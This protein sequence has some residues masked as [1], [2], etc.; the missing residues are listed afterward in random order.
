MLKLFNTLSKTTEEI[1]T[2]DEGTIRMYTCGPT[3]YRYAHIGNLR[4]YMMADWIRRTLEL[5]GLNVVHVKN[6]T[7]VGHMR[8]ELVE[9]GGDKMILAALAEGKTIE[10]IAQ[11]YADSFHEDE[12]RVNILPAHV[13]PWAT[14]HIPEMISIVEKLVANG[15]AYEVNGNIYFDVE[16]FSDYGKLSRNFGGDLLEGVRVEADPLKKDPRDFTLWKSAEAGRDVKW[17]SPWG[18]G[19][20]GWHIECSAMAHKYLGETFDIHTG[21]VDNV[22]PHHEDEIAQ[23]E[24]AFGSQHVTY[25]IHGQHLLADGAKMSKS[26]GNV[27]L[28]QDLIDRG[29][30]P[31]AFRYLCGTVRYRHRMNFTFTSLKGAEKA[32]TAL[33]RKGQEW[34]EHNKTSVNVSSDCLAWKGKFWDSVNNDLGIPEAIAILWDMTRS[35]LPDNE[36]LELFNDFDRILGVGLTSFNPDKS[37]SHDIGNSLE[38]R[39]GLRID[40]QYTEAD[41]VRTDII[42]AGFDVQDGHTSTQLRPKTRYEQIEAKWPSVSASREV[43]SLLE[44]PP[45]YDYSFILNAYNYVSDIQRCVQS[46]LRNSTAYSTEVIVVDN[47]STD[48]TGDWLEE[49]AGECSSLKVI[50]CDHVIGDAAGK[51]IGLKQARGK[52]II[53]ID[54]ST[55][56]TGDLLN[57]V[58]QYL[59]DEEIGI[60]GPY[61]LSTDD[62][63]HFHEE[64]DKGYADAI[65]A[66]CMAFRRDALLSVGLMNEGYRFYRNL[67]IDYSFQFKDKGYSVFADSTLPLVRH[68]HRQ[69]TELDDN[70]RDELSRKNFGRF[71]KRW[72]QRADLLLNADGKAFETGFRH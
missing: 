12:K 20:P 67:D 1:C 57:F 35:S 13:Y 5:E 9:T 43:A 8:Q 40:K 21:G 17:E 3:V 66:Y 63:Q 68:E 7:D 25:W 6:I 23:S 16:K 4:T 64:V 24:A 71:L 22:F 34:L 37:I 59:S 41:A 14:D 38:K 18:E 56:V 2:L 10:Q 58:G 69:W 45:I 32:L 44:E 50:H 60:L 62:M 33:R 39:T 48:G 49:F 72:G 30:D 46:I 70:Q 26:A 53:I 61:G 36:K 54:A 19:F 29:F 52:N 47:G 15:Y 55:E 51:N 27:F 31:L 42:S 11:F 28:L 65:Q